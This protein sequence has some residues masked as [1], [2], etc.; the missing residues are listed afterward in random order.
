M[1]LIRHQYEAN[2]NSQARFDEISWEMRYY[3]SILDLN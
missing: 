2:M 1:P 3:I